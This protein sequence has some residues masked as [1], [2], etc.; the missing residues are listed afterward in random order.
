MNLLVNQATPA[1]PNEVWMRVFWHIGDGRTLRAVILTSR[2]FQSLAADEI[3]RTLIWS[4][5]KKAHQNIDFWEDNADRKHIPTAL[6]LTLHPRYRRRKIDSHPEVLNRI[7]WFHNLGHLS[8]S[9]GN[10]PILFYHLLLNLP[11]LTH[12]SLMECGIPALP[13]N[14]PLS[15]PS[16]S[17]PSIDP[18][19]ISI[20]NLSLRNVSEYSPTGNWAEFSYFPSSLNILKF[21]PRLRA[22]T[23]DAGIPVGA[24]VL[25]Q[26]TS[27]TILPCP[28]SELT[29]QTLNFRLQHAVNLLHLSV[30]TPLIETPRD[31]PHLITTPLPLLE[32]LAGPQFVVQRVLCESQSLVSLKVDAISKAEDALRIVE[33]LNAATLRSIE[34]DVAEWDDELILAITHRLF[35]CQSVKVTFRFSHPSDSFLF[36]LGVEHLP[37][38]QDLHTLCIHSRPAEDPPVQGEQDQDDE[39]YLP[40]LI[41]PHWI[42]TPGPAQVEGQQETR[43]AAAAV[44]PDEETCGEYVAAWTRYNHNL[45]HIRFVEG[46]AWVRRFVGG[47]WDVGTIES[48]V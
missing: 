35:A 37:L 19:D 30:G 13:P 17:D 14:F 36:N 20:T 43:V 28:S 3:F 40:V 26:L 42:Y 16:F 18:I 41:Q 48:E 29:I 47:R 31:T 1:L 38:L 44:D 2:R 8:L 45:R 46:R 4:T 39:D 11:R 10:L 22:L 5:I 12:L 7:S 21:L 15:F 34:L 33:M 25:Q 9:N 24:S 27:L 32:T 6:S 23:V